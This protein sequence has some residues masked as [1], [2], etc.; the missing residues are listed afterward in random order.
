[1]RQSHTIELL[2]CSKCDGGWVAK[3]QVAH[4]I[5]YALV[6]IYI[7]AVIVWLHATFEK[8]KQKIKILIIK[9]R[10]NEAIKPLESQQAA[11]LAFVVCL[12][13][14]FVLLVQ[15]IKLTFAIFRT[16]LFF[17]FW[18]NDFRKFLFLSAFV[19]I[20]ICASLAYCCC[21]YFLQY[22]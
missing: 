9:Q 6:R 18:F 7:R 15:Q 2:H 13:S 3:L 20:A 10:S 4:I 5:L 21:N 22:F 17:V 14:F 11:W 16:C 1:M 19:F 8:K 12:P